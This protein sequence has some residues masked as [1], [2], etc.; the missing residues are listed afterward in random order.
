M[1]IHLNLIE[2]GW[3]LHFQI[4]RTWTPDEILAAKKDTRRIFEQAT[5]PVHALA[6]LR[7]A[8]V[9]VALLQASSQVIGGEPLPNSGQIAVVGVSWMLRMIAT[10][11][12]SLAVGN[13]PVTFFDSYDEAVRFLKRYIS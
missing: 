5:H 4:E 9:N 12:L 2:N 11:L 3:I 8:A 1:P 10:P 6:D 7:Q 13:D